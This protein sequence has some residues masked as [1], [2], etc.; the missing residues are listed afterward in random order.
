MQ[1]ATQ[2]AAVLT[3][4]EAAAAEPKAQGGVLA[5]Q[6]AWT[7][8][9]AVKAQKPEEVYRLTKAARA[10]VPVMEETAVLAAVAVTAVAMSQSACRPH[11]CCM[12]RA[13]QSLRS[14]P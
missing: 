1:V 7:G 6:S 14:S 3:A 13:H 10:V 2:E 8:V 5:R 9:V 11:A 12:L 4:A